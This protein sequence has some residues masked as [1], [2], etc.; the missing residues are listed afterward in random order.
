MKNYVYS[1]LVF[2]NGPPQNK[3]IMMDLYKGYHSFQLSN[4]FLGQVIRF[5]IEILVKMQK[6]DGEKLPLKLPY[7]VLPVFQYGWLKGISPIVTKPRQ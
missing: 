5:L 4:F 7:T 2:L 1:I 3:L 6:D